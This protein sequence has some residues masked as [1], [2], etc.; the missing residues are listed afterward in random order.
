MTLV[1]PST[2]RRQRWRS[3][4][5][6]ALLVSLALHLYVFFVAWLV[7]ELM[8]RGW[9]P[10]W[11]KP[12]VA[13]VAPAVVANLTAKAPSVPPPD[14]EIPLQFIEVDPAL[15]AT[16]PP[17]DAQFM[18]TANTVLANPVPA[19][20]AKREPRIDGRREDTL[21]TFE[22]VRPTKV[23]EPVVPEDLVKEIA[24]EVMKPLPKGGLKPGDLARAK[25]VP[26]AKTDRPQEARE[27]QESSEP[28]VP[29]QKKRKTV[30]QARAERGMMVGEQM[31][32]DGGAPR[33]G[34]EP[35]FNVKATQFGEYSSRLTA[36][37]QARWYHLLDERHYSLERTGKV[38]VRFKL[39]PD[40]S[41]SAIKTAFDTTG[42]LY[43]LLCEL[44]IE[45]PAPFGKWP[46]ALLHE[47][48]AEPV[49]VTFTFNYFYN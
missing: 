12:V 24:R 38:V 35:T 37:V 8:R 39:H 1:L 32:L 16:E 43:S 15:A 46:P 7:P 18:S 11:L 29:A 5:V 4:L 47:I 33:F 28:K 13:A 31:K 42:E 45:Q 30:S 44:A 26:E 10:E 2:G 49:E 3:P 23:V 14:I 9:I 40:G 34:I 36:A 20:E 21:R 6:V 22:T 48:G 25:P 41:V 27:A 17:K 19:P